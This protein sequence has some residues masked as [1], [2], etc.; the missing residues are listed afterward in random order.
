MF[1]LPWYT[2]LS[3]T[4]VPHSIPSCPVLKR[5]LVYSMYS[6]KLFDNLSNI[7]VLI[8]CNHF[9]K[10][11]SYI[12]KN[13]ALVPNPDLNSVCVFLFRNGFIPIHEDS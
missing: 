8:Y 1:D 10:Y 5:K 12:K 4:F 6:Q 2:R 11:S 13:P 3:N 9:L 7:C